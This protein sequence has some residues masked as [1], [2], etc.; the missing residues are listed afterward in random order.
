MLANGQKPKEKPKVFIS[1]AHE[2]LKEVQRLYE[3][4]KKADC[5]PWID[6]KNLL[7]GQKWKYIIKK[8]IKSSDFFLACFSKKSV[9]KI[10]FFQTE[11]KEA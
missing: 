8:A 4:L 1:Y 11:L 6:K 9:S 5:S 3:M 10:G 7:P 2:D